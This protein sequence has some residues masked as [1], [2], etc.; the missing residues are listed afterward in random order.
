MSHEEKLKRR[1]ACA[2]LL[3]L[4]GSAL[5]VSAA[6]AQE[7]RPKI[8]AGKV[9]VRPRVMPALNNADFYGPDGKFNEDAAKKAYFDLMRFYNYPVNDNIRKN[10]FVS[11]LGLGKFTEAGLAA[12]VLINEKQ[13]NYAALEVFLLPNQ[14]IPEHWHVAQKED[15]VAEKLESWVVRYGSTFTYGVGD[16]TDPIAV[17][18]PECQKAFV[19]VRREKQLKPGDT[20]GVAKPLDRHWQLAGPQGCIFTEVATYHAGT[21]VRFADPKIKF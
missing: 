18:I 21:A 12:V 5:A 19:T 4:G 8:R 13:G 16:P 20:A 11:D 10:I 9:A 1:A 6:S 17:N 14:M 3:G 2:A 7:G 15:G